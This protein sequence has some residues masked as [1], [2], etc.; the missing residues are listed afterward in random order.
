VEQSAAIQFRNGA[1]AQDQGT[2]FST[3][4]VVGTAALLMANFS[5]YL[6]GNPTLTRAVLLA[7]ARHT[8]AGQPPVPLFND[9]IDD[10]A[11]AG[12]PRGDR[13]KTILA[14]QQF[15]PPP[16]S[17][18]HKVSGYVDRNADFNSTGFLNTPILFDTNAGDRVRVVLTYDQ[19]QADLVSL[20]D[21][22]IADLDLVVNEDAPAVHKVHAN[23]SHLDNTEI[24][25]FTTDVHSQITVKTKAQF[26]KPCSDGTLKTYMAIAWD[27]LGAS[28]K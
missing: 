11:G 4:F 7:S 3:P 8:F 1:Y 9:G 17:T 13:A 22:L 18:T 19:C 27:V 23:N 28:E 14:N 6:V 10:R 2:S 20:N 12:A 26:W 24:V 5:Q 15:W 25:E 16:D 21:S